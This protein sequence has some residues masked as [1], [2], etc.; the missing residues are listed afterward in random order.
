MGI[1]FIEVMPLREIEDGAHSK[2]KAAVVKP[3]SLCRNR[4][5]ERAYKGGRRA[6]SPRPDDHCN[7]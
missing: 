7:A 1:T 2:A 5:I 4:H 3:S 6:L